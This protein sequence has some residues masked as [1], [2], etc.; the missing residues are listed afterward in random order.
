MNEKNDDD[1][2]VGVGDLA[3]ILT[4]HIVAHPAHFILLSHILRIGPHTH[5]LIVF[6]QHTRDINLPH[7]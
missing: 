4:I 5:K 3:L 1:D 2:A 7:T 6:A